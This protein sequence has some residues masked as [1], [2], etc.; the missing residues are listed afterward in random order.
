MTNAGIPL[1]AC[2]KVLDYEFAW[3]AW[4]IVLCLQ[5][6]FIHLLSYHPLSWCRCYSAML[7]TYRRTRLTFQNSFRST[8]TQALASCPIRIAVFF[9]QSSSSIN[10]LVSTRILSL[11]LMVG[12]LGFGLQSAYTRLAKL[13]ISQGW[14][15]IGNFD[16]IVSPHCRRLFNILSSHPIRWIWL[17]SRCKIVSLHSVRKRIT[18]DMKMYIYPA[19][20]SE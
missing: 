3:S 14:L 16:A 1:S 6:S 4:L 20:L 5:V 15:S 19:F 11:M 17:P 9:P 2:F 8:L 7:S 10:P 18:V 12:F 13:L